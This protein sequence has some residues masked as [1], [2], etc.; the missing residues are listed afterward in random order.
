MA[1]R[2]PSAAVPYITVISQVRELTL[3]GS[4]DLSFWQRHLAREGLAPTPAGGRAQL[5]LSAPELR[6]GGVRFRELSLGVVAGAPPAGA[7]PTGLALVCAAN[8]SRALAFLERTLFQTPY[9]HLPIAVEASL[10]ASMAVTTSA[11]TSL[12]AAMAPRAAPEWGR[13]DAWEGAIFLP[14]PA[15]GPA[16][17]RWFRARLGGFTVA[18]RFNPATDTLALKPGADAGLA[19]LLIDSQFAPEEWRIRTDATHARSR[20]YTG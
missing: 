14:S 20:T 18:Y 13:D 7:P 11:G 1:S 9:V 4:A 6:W 5:I 10:P 12:H 17:R 16:R 3:L 19:K 8:S 2:P 15:A